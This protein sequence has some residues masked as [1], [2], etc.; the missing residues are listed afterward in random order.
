MLEVLGASCAQRGDGSWHCELILKC[1]DGDQLTL[2]QDSPVREQA[3]ALTISELCSS[4]IEIYSFNVDQRDS[5]RQV[6]ALVRELERPESRSENHRSGHHQSG[7]HQSG[8]HRSLNSAA[9][10]CRAG[11]GRYVS[12]DEG[13][14]LVIAAL[15][16][17]SH[18]GMLRADYRA[19]NQKVLREWSS[20]LIA[21]L[22]ET[23]GIGELDDFKRLA[24]E[25]VVLEHLNRVASAA[26]VT[27]ANHPRPDSILSLFD[28]SAWLFDSQGNRRDSY[29]DTRLWLAWYPGIENGHLTVDEVIESM[30]KAPPSKIPWIVRL[31]E[32]P[33][34]WIRFRGAVDLEDHDVM[35]VLLGRGLQDQDEAFVLG[36]AMGTAK[37]ISRFQYWVFKWALAR[38][39]PEPYR[40]PKFLQPAFDLGVRCGQET[41]AKDLYQ[42]PL[43]DLRSLPLAEARSLAEIDMRVVRKYYEAE[44][45]QIPFTI[46]SLRLP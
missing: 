7:H 43:K 11:V 4:S 24:A 22:N 6:V 34:S 36:F 33:E 2:S 45:Q 10:E 38:L 19:N 1:K 31:F 28:T 26:V 30:P 37:R 32:N 20:E 15:R 16:A 17:A 12:E 41:G 13:A 23:L 3:V 42:R 14:G 29:T 8:H 44:Q 39:Y 40:I 35:H 46:A 18:A 21:E 27:A 9:D 25:G 5:L